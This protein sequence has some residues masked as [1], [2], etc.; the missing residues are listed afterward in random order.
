MILLVTSVMDNV[1]GPKLKTPVEEVFAVLYHMASVTIVRNS[2]ARH[3]D[4]R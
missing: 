2:V 3:T 1:S 4:K